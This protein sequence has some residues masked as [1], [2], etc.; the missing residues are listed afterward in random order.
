MPWLIV[1]NWK[2]VGVCSYI[3]FGCSEGPSYQLFFSFNFNVL[4]IRKGSNIRLE[5]LQNNNFILPHEIQD[6]SK[7]KLAIHLHTPTY[8]T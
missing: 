2:K 8:S 7:N 5:N 1:F 4:K 6:A 3:Y